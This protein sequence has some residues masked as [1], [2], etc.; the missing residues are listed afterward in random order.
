MLTT[1]E[2]LRRHGLPG[3]TLDSKNTFEKLKNKNS[4]IILGESED[5]MSQD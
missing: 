4:D 3:S 2:R 5:I 1:K